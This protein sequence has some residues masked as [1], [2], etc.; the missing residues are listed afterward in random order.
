MKVNDDT[1]EFCLTT[2]QTQGQV[3]IA[4]TLPLLRCSLFVLRPLRSAVRSLLLRSR[5]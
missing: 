5:R 3:K 1:Q 4:S 2:L